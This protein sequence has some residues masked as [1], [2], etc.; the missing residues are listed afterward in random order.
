MQ[1]AI[2]AGGSAL[3]KAKGVVATYP[4]IWQGS[5]LDVGCR[6]REMEKA[7]TGR[8]INYSGLDLGSPADVV[9]NLDEGIPLEDQDVDIVTALDVIEHTNDFHF[10][11]AEICRVA[12][13]HVV[14]SLPNTY[15]IGVRLRILRGQPVSAKYG[16]PPSH[17]ADRHHWFFSLTEA[18]RFMHA[19]A[20]RTGWRVADERA[21]IG[22]RRGRYA[23]LVSRYPNLGAGTYLCHLERVAP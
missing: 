4:A 7:L 21:I 2:F 19:N 22:P 16:L 20:S 14:V 13:K 8:Q 23:P 6:S 11:F 5:L 17:V 18:S 3:N 12:H 1:T 10:T 15:E 9:A